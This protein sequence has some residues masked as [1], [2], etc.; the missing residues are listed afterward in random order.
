MGAVMARSRV[1]LPP[2]VRPPFEVY[3]NGVRQELGEDYEVREGTLEFDRPLAKEG[4]LGFWRWF[5]GAWGIGTYRQNDSV[6]VRYEVEGRPVV[7]EALEIE[8]A[9]EGEV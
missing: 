2:N 9:E 6:D 4:R 3:I 5:M 7:A 8:P 1:Q